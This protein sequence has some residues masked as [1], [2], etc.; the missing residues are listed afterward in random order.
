[1]LLG[2][3]GGTAKS[4]GNHRLGKQQ[5]AEHAVGCNKTERRL[6]WQP[7]Q[8]VAS[9][10]L[11][12]LL[13]H[14]IPLALPPKPDSAH[15]RLLVSPTLQPPAAE[16][17]SHRSISPDHFQSCHVEHGLSSECNCIGAAYARNPRLTAAV[18]SVQVSTWSS[19]GSA[20]VLA[21]MQQRHSA[22]G[23]LLSGLPANNRLAGAGCKSGQ[24][25]LRSVSCS[26]P[27][28]G[29]SRFQLGAVLLQQ[30]HEG[31][32]CRQCRLAH[33]WRRVHPQGSHRRDDALGGLVC[34]VS[35]HSGHH[36][37]QAERRKN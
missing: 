15:P 2:A 32:Q 4:L 12:D 24:R 9:R 5:I 16:P 20:M 22:Q 17:C 18:T 35:L 28:R 23:S 11:Q 30:A 3:I 33:F 27:R 19:H 31:V 6:S 1:M 8:E 21:H 14:S 25:H 10:H 37:L 7:M 34:G 36:G 26:S 29:G 13:T